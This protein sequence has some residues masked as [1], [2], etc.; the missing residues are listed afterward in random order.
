[1]PR[2][3]GM[4]KQRS[5]LSTLAAVAALGLLAACGTESAN[6]GDGSG[7]GGS[8]TVEPE[9]PV[10]GVHWSV[11][12]L[13][14]GGEKLDA[15]QRAYV[16]FDTK[17][18]VGG[19]YGCNRFGADYT[20][21][22][23]TLTVQPSEMTE[24]GCGK[25]I[26]KFEDAFA[27]ALTGALTAEVSGD[28]LTLTTKKGD[29]VELAEEKPAPLKGT[30][31][32]VSGYA[33]D[34]GETHVSLPQSAQG[35]PHF[36]IADDGAVRGNLGCNDFTSKARITD[37]RITF[38]APATTT[39]KMCEKGQMKAE[40]RLRKVFEGTAEYEVRH[41]A[42]VLTKDGEGLHASAPGDPDQE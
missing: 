42:L 29:T 8:R 28:R 30:R 18:R 20:A 10:T 19:N 41:R 6:G 5:T 1:M 35:K 13:T 22:G 27:R 14:T 40:D 11:T 16:T 36:K 7:A 9:V 23:E 21:E 37:G 32:S 17:G 39:R 3:S 12:S 15:P 25:D 24:I 31:W 38:E 26:Q 4:D 34:D 2:Q 33:E